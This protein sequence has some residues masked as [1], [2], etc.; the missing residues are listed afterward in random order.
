MGT[1]KQ[2]HWG[3]RIGIVLAMA[4]NAVGFGNFLRFPMQAISNGGGAFIIPYIVCFVLLGIPLTF[5]EWTIGRYSGQFGCHS[6]PAVMGKMG[7]KKIWLFAG[8]FGLFS[9]LAIASYYCYIESWTLSYVYH[10]IAGTFRGLSHGDVSLFFSNYHAPGRPQDGIPCENI[11][12]FV[13]CLALNIWILCKGLQGGIEK[14]AKAGIPLLLLLGIFLAIKGICIKPDVNG[15]VAAGLD[16]LNFLWTPHYQSLLDPKVWLAAAGQIFFTLS[17]GMGCIQ[18]YASFLRKDEDIALGALTTGFLNEFVEIVLGGTII[19]SIAVGF[20]GLDGLQ[21]LIANESGFGIAFQSMPFLFQKMGPVIGVICGIA[22]FG[23]LFIAGITSSLAMSTP[24]MSFL[25][26]RFHV[27][28]RNAALIIGGTILLCGLPTVLFFKHGVFDEY[29]YWAGTI[30]LFFFALLETI[31]FSWVFGIRNSWKELNRAAEIRLPKFF[32]F[33]LQYITPT[34]LIIILLAALIKP[35]ND[36][37]SKLSLKGWEVDK[38]SILGKLMNKGIGPNNTW[39]ADT[40]YS[41]VDGYYA[42]LYR[43]E[44]NT[45]LNVDCYDAQL[46]Q[47]VGY[48]KAYKV[49]HDSHILIQKGDYV[50]AGTPIMGGHFVNDCFYIA[51]ARYFLLTLFILLFILIAIAFKKFPVTQENPNS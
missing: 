15:A 30:S 21:S 35:E 26:Y 33:I 44:G 13:L 49:R 2:E 36:D 41:E 50:T 1:V 38:T 24:I 28:K 20:F 37:W 23:L 25:E 6:T 9:N 17:V 40:L 34:M 7:K 47:R 27:S 3:S 48:T 10:T 11:V 51:L 29:D 8:V 43:H 16:G 32:K 45:Y 12:F 19:I 42:G 31:L 39:F 46:H 22:F 5:V 14:V 18:C 4:G